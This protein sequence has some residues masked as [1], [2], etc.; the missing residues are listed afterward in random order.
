MPKLTKAKYQIPKCPACGE[1]LEVVW[2]TEFNT[3][4]F[5]PKVGRYEH[6]WDREDIEIRCSHCESRAVED[7]FEEGCCNYRAK[8]IK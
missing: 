4:V 2:E 6:N 7:I 3:Y 8:K 5:N 1:K